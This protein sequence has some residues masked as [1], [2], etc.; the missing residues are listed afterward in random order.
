[1]KN[2]QLSLVIVLDNSSHNTDAVIEYLQTKSILN[3]NNQETFKINNTA[4]LFWQRLEVTSSFNL[5][6]IR[7]ELEHKFGSIEVASNEFCNN[8]SL[9]DQII[10]GGISSLISLPI[11]YGLSQITI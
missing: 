10:V 9:T 11:G 4:V 8:S 6:E 7:T 5:K 2:I 1:M 3:I